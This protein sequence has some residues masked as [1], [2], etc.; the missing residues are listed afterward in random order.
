M[1]VSTD[2]VD[3]RQIL[4]ELHSLTKIAAENTLLVGDKSND[5]AIYNLMSLFIAPVNAVK[6][7]HREADFVLTPNVGNSCVRQLNDEI[8]KG[9]E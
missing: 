9:H 1:H 4:V 8:V 5:L 3:Q 7:G 2:V 6:Y